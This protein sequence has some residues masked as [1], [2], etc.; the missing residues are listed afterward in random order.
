MRHSR[1][2]RRWCLVLVL[3]AL[4]GYT[5]CGGG[6]TSRGGGAGASAG[7]VRWLKGKVTLHRGAQ[8]LAVDASAS[9][10]VQNG[11]TLETG[12]DS[13]A[14]ITA[15]KKVQ[16]L[17]EKTQLK[18]DAL[19]EGTNAGTHDRVSLLRGLATFFLPAHQQGYQFEAMT[20]TVAAAVKGTIFSL[21]AG[22]TGVRATVIR[23]EVALLPVDA[24]GATGATPLAT[25]TADQRASVSNGEVKREAVSAAE[26]SSLKSDLL[27]K[28]EQLQIDVT[29]M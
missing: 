2:A 11:D 14:V 22:D 25:L 20:S 5:G 13:E 19:V 10:P 23:G 24:G 16:V 6:S 15:G 28:K 17:A 4:V 12:P 18:I 21:E 26:S 1:I 9:V 3:A 7:A 29:T 8:D 27:L